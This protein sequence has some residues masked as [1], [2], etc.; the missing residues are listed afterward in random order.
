MATLTVQ[1][2]DRDGVAITAVAAAV[3]GDQFINNGKTYIYIDNGSGAPITATLA[4]AGTTQG[5]AI[6]DQTVVVAAGEVVIAGVYS[7]SLFNDANRMIQVT[8]TAVTSVTVAVLSQ[9]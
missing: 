9:E 4:T 3:G 7:T 8:Y 5:L 1:D 6:A 2:I